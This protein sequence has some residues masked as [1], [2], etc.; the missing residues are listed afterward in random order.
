MGTVLNQSNPVF[1]PTH[2]I[3]KIHLNTVQDMG[4]A[5]GSR[6]HHNEPFGSIKAGELF[7]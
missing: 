1:I 7:D 4:A 5:V 3:C 6:E 2:H